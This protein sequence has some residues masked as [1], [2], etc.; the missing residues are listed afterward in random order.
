MARAAPIRA[1]PREQATLHTPYALGGLPRCGAHGGTGHRRRRWLEEFTEQ[2]REAATR[3]FSL[4]HSWLL[5]T[6]VP[7]EV[8]M[9][10][11][12]FALWKKLGNFCGSV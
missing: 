11:K 3:L 10:P 2:E 7:D 1:L 8:R 12:T 9:T 5:T 4:S 6:G